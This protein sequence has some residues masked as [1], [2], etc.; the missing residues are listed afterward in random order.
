MN[1]FSHSPYLL[2]G[3]IPASDSIFLTKRGEAAGLVPNGI[4]GPSAERYYGDG[5]NKFATQI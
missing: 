5:G 4:R 2:Q 1:I 3:S